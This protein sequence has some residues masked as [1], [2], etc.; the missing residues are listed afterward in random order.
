[1]Y[2]LSSLIQKIR[3]LLLKK[4]KKTKTIT[5]SASSNSSNK[6]KPNYEVR[7]NAATGPICFGV[8]GYDA[9]VGAGAESRGPSSYF[10]AGEGG[11]HKVAIRRDQ[12]SL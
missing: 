9:L 11:L 7:G 6:V 10:Y 4:N 1:M 3:R 8:Y 12:A 2:G 5:T